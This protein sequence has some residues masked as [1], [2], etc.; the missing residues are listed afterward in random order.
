MPNMPKTGCRINDCGKP[1]A[2]L[3]EGRTLRV[4]DDFRACPEHQKELVIALRKL[5]GD[6]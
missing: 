1:F 3:E 6:W 4:E 2:P 5:R